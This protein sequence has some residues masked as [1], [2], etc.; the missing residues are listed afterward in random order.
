MKKSLTTLLQI[1]IVLIGI[2]VLAFMLW[3][4]RFEGRNAHA[5]LFEVYFRDPFLIYAYIASIAFFVALYQSIKILGYI[6]QNNLYSQ[7]SLSSLRII[8]YSATILIIFV[9]GALSYLFIAMRG[10]DD[11]AGGVAMG[12]FIILI[13][14][15][16][17]A[18][19]VKLEIK[20][21]NTLSAKSH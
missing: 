6:G 17:I 19:T 11:I 21:L 3:E 5:T 9:A 14:I 15:L 10:K 16:I 1:L 20:L 7:D 12:S 18:T 4:P 2:A 8:K 13:S